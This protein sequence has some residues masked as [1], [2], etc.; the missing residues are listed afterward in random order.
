VD[1]FC[2]ALIKLKSGRTV[3]LEVSWAAAMETHDVNGVQV[4]G[5]EGGAT[6]NP[7]RWYR[8]GV[9]GYEITQLAPVGGYVP[10]N[11]MA[12]FID[13]VQGKAKPF[14]PPRQSLA[15]QRILDGIYESAKTG[16][17]VRL[18]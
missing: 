7:L 8:P 16:R 13:V 12:H 1:D 3:Q 9:D 14:V 18:D 17:E 2:V 11:R 5:T 6:T 15:I 4:F 10:E